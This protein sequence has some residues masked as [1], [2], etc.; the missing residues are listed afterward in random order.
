MGI[1]SKIFSSPWGKVAGLIVDFV[2]EWRKRRAQSKAQKQADRIAD[3][4]TVSARR[5]FGDDRD[6]AE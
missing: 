3:N 1:L 5:M 4:P 2:R 6:D